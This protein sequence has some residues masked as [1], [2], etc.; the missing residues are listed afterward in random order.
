[1]RWTLWDGDK[2][3]LQLHGVG[4]V[5]IS[6]NTKDYEAGAVIALPDGAFLSCGVNSFTFDTWGGSR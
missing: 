4:R 3:R 5:E 1:M 6:A 2:A